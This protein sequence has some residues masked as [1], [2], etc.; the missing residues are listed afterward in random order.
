MIRLATPF[1]NLNDIIGDIPHDAIWLLIG[2]GFDYVR[3]HRKTLFNPKNMRKNF[4]WFQL[5]CLSIVLICSY[6]LEGGFKKIHVNPFAR[7]MN[8]TYKKILKT[9]FKIFYRIE[10]ELAYQSFKWLEG[11]VTGCEIGNITGVFSFNEM[12]EMSRQ[13]TERK[14][15]GMCC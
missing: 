3:R 6:D 9:G 14:S 13:L 10:P 4:G 5:F 8:E 12:K 2:Q 11:F 1:P 15:E 7:I